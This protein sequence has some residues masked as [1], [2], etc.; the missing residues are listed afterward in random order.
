MIVGGIDA[1]GKAA[2]EAAQN[3]ANNADDPVS[4]AV[5]GAAAGGIVALGAMIAFIIL[6]FA[7]AIPLLFTI[8]FLIR[9]NFVETPSIALGV[10]TLILACIPAGIL[11]L[12]QKGLSNKNN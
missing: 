4:G 6:A 10:L 12:V 1:A 7:F 8:I 3:T 9:Y 2:Q 5:G 11:M